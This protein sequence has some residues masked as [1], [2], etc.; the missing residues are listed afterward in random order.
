MENADFLMNEAAEFIGRAV[1]V[2]NGQAGYIDRAGNFYP[3]KHLELFFQK[4][5]ISMKLEEF[6]K[7]YNE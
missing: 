7:R 1:V 5:D 6:I 2:L 3:E 4:T